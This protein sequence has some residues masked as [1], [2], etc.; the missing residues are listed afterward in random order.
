M[1][2]FAYFLPLVEYVC[3]MRN[4]QFANTN[5]TDFN[6]ITTNLITQLDQE[7]LRVDRNT[8][9]LAKLA[10]FSWVDETV[11]RSDWTD[12][13]QWQNKLLQERYLE[14]ANA[15]EAFFTTLR[16]FSES[17]QDL[18]RIYYR[19]LVLGFRGKYYRD[20][21]VLELR[22]L[23]QQCLF[24]LNIKIDQNNS[25][26]EKLFPDLYQSLGAQPLQT[27]SLLAKKWYQNKWLLWGIPPVVLLLVYGFFYGILHLTVSNYLAL[28]T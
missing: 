16:Q 8:L 9:I 26:N 19:C 3:Q 11:Q 4:T 5:F 13:I 15:G 2:L 22:K 17:D 1:Q 14:T 18:I 6:A 10:V 12:K 28:L 27:G 24:L 20:E 21:D 23:K 25:E 7:T